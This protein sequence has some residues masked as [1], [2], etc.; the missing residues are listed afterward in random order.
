VEKEA[1]GLFISAHPLKPLREALRARVDCQLASLAERRDKDLV[2]VGGIIVEAKRIR[3]RNGDPMMFAT[4]DDLGG[5]VEMLVFGKALAEHEAALAVDE[6]VLVT[7][8]V[9]HKEATKT[10]LIVQAVER[11]SPSQEEI[12]SARARPEHGPSAPTAE[13][14]P[15]HLRVDPTR[16]SESAIDDLK[17]AIED[18]PGPAEVVLDL[19]TSD[20]TRRLRLGDSY[21]V[22]HTPALRA[23]LEQALAPA[24]EAPAHEVPAPATPASAAP[25]SAASAAG[26]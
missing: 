16:L 4:L 6:V 10:C 25:A 21:R 23:Q 13:A 17:Q 7:G 18:F 20:G 14:A 19:D 24:S 2:T 22:L 26:G 12:E 11:F 5:T 3:T 1:I 9:D 8:R 15:V